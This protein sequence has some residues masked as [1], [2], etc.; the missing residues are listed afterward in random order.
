MK[1]KLFLTLAFLIFTSSF[2][3]AQ[4][5]ACLLE[6][7]DSPVLRGMKLGMTINE[8]E[9]VL[10]ARLEVS[11]EGWAISLK[12]VKNEYVEI[13]YDD[14]LYAKNERKI[15]NVYS[16]IYIKETESLPKLSGVY[17]L[18]LRF[19]KN[20]LY[21]VNITYDTPDYTWK[22]AKEFLRDNEE[23]MNLPK[24]LW[25]SQPKRDVFQVSLL[26]CS[27]F[28]AFV[29]VAPESVSLDVEDKITEKLIVL[30]AKRLYIEELKEN[31]REKL[32]KKKTFKP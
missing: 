32:E 10:V 15:D 12:K 24:G 28:T 18:V 13:S 22:T 23:K 31:E 4:G 3:V 26:D 21:A 6:I 20:S 17:S 9:K 1:Y 8:I 19:F 5:K 16:R 25:S 7:K 30:E 11:S 2:C 29:T 14:P 27:G